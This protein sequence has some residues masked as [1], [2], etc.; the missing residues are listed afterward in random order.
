MSV[1]TAVLVTTLTAGQPLGS[2]TVVRQQGGAG[3]QAYGT[4]QPALIQAGQVD[5]SDQ[6]Q[7]SGAGGLTAAGI[8]AVAGIFSTYYGGLSAAA[9]ASLGYIRASVTSSGLIMAVNGADVAAQAALLVTALNN[10]ANYG[11]VGT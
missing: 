2:V 6:V 5:T 11:P 1:G 8:V 9:K 3:P 7:G 10:A 4:V